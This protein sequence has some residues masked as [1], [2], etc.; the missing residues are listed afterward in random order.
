VRTFPN[1]VT[2]VRGRY[3]HGRDESSFAMAIMVIVS[4]IDG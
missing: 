3:K 1:M 2:C 4:Y